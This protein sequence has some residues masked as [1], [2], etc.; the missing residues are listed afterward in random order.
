MTEAT[1]EAA[2]PQ[3]SYE[4]NFDLDGSSFA[5]R[6]NLADILERE[7]LGP[8]NGPEELLPFSP[9]SQYLVG[10]IAP[11]K[12][13][14][15]KSSALGEDDTARDLVEVRT[16]DDG[17]A[18]G[19]GVPAY[20]ADETEADS[21][22][23]DA[24]DRAPK[25]GLMIP[26]SMGLRFQVPAGPGV[27]RGDVR[28]G[29]STSPSRPTRCRRPAGRS[30]TTSASR[31]RSDARSDSPTWCLARQ[32]RL[33]LRDDACLRV[34]RYDDPQFG[35]VLV[36]IALCNDRETP[37]PIP[38]SMWMFQTKLLVD[39][40]GAEVFLPVRDVL[41]QDWPEHDEEVKRLNLQYRNRLE[42]AIGRTCSVDWAVKDGSRRAT[43]VET[44]WLPVGETPQTRARSVEGRAAVDGRAGEGRTLT[45]CAPGWSRWSTGYGAWLDEQ[46]AEAAKLPA[47]WQETVRGGVVGGP[48]GT[49]AARRRA[50]A[51][52]HA[53]RRRCGASSS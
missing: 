40:G 32:R 35:R 31:S 8:I 48:A 16:D 12:L 43:S 42:F 37:M 23:D 41:E 34:D 39:A 1:T 13:N 53:T 28:R 2:G 14:G 7:L 11:V 25:Q 47:H 29:A 22:E 44:T 15:V 45:S 4:L 21:D 18:E 36:E 49:R 30:A 10:H 20:A 27:L 19:R 33:P 9:R 46:E 5:V 52:R 50:G 26:A 3:A 38:L 17:L 24:E 51:C 6:E